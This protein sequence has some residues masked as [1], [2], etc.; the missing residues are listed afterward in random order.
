MPPQLKAALVRALGAAAAAAVAAFGASWFASD[1]AAEKVAESV[2]APVEA[3]PTTDGEERPETE[4][5]SDDVDS[6]P[7][8]TTVQ[9]IGAGIAAVLVYG[10]RGLGEGFYDS[11]RAKDGNVKKGDVSRELY[12]QW[13]NTGDDWFEVLGVIRERGVD[14]FMIATGTDHEPRW[15]PR[16]EVTDFR[17]G[18]GPG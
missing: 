3:P 8:T 12:V 10:V 17:Y 16:S 4:Q 6:D 18:A 11:K 15:I 7:D 9:L 2:T 14:K 13:A 1:Q 5:P